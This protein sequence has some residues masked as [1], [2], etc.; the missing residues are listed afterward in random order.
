MTHQE[1]L[2]VPEL[3]VAENIYMADLP[4][5][6]PWPL[7]AWKQAFESV[8]ELLDSLSTNIDSRLPMRK[9]SIAET[10]M[11]SI[12]RAVYHE[13]DVIVLDEPTSSFNFSEVTILFNLMHSL[14]EKNTAIIFIS[15]RLQE[16]LEIADV[17]SVLRDGKLVRTMA[18]SNLDA[19][20][21]IMM[22]CGRELERKEVAIREIQRKDPLVVVKNLSDGKEVQGVS[23]ELYRGEILGIAGLLGS[24]KDRLTKSLVTGSYTEGEVFIKGKRVRTSSPRHSQRNGIG[25]LPPDRHLEGLVPLLSVRENI[26]LQAPVGSSILTR[27]RKERQEAE[28]YAEKTHVIAPRGVEQQVETLSGGNQ[29]KVL[30][31]RI[32][33]LQA[34][35]LVLHEPTRGIDVGA[36]AEVQNL[37]REIARSGKAILMCSSETEEIVSMSDRVLVMQG[38]RVTAELEGSEITEEAVVKASLAQ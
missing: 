14:K 19:E 15:H 1:T 3:T 8:Q 37:I 27:K 2:F 16:V 24:G 6:G 29:Q 25:Y 22:M 7:V 11:I 20:K 10:V 21:L 34:D 12:A 28:T 38:G 26:F 35:I 30:M 33:A 23:F 9:L 36:K 4:T 5:T 31:S 32:M 18:S 17:V 13:S